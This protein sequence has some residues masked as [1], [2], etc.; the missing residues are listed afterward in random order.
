VIT[1]QGFETTARGDVS[2]AAAGETSVDTPLAIAP[3]QEKV[4]VTESG[5]PLGLSAEQAA[6]AI[7]I[8]GTQLDALPD[9]PD[10]LSDALQALAGSAAGP[11]GGEIFVDG[12]SNGRIPPKSA[13]LQIRLN[14]TP[15]SAEYDHPGFGRIEII[16][17]PGSDTYHGQASVR[18]NSSALNTRDPFSSNE[19]DYH[20]LTA[21]ADTSGPLVKG[22]ASY[23][24]DFERR[25]IDNAQLVNATVMDPQFTLQ[26]FNRSLVVPQWRTSVSP[27]LDLQ[28]GS[29]NALTLR[30]AYTQTEQDNAGIGGFVLPS[31]AYDITSRQH[32]VQVGDTGVYGKIVNEL[33]MQWTR[34]ESGQTPLAFD[35]TVE[36]QDAFTSG[37]ATVGLSNH[38]EDHLE[39]Q[40]VLSVSKG[41]HSIRTGFRLRDALVTDVSR[42]GFNG[43]VTF[44]GTFGPEL[45]AAG[46]PVLGPDG[47]PVLVPVTSIERYRR[48]M[49]LT[50]LGYSA[51]QI[52]SLGG[53][54]SQ[55]QL[56]G[57]DPYASVRQWD[58]GAFLQD[59]WKVRP[60]LTLGLGMRLESQSNLS[61]DVDIAPRLY[62][63]WSPGFTGRGTPKTVLRAGAGV[64]YD[65]VD[66]SLVL[67]ARRFDGGA[68]KRFLVTDP[69]ILDQIAYDPTTGDVTSLPAF[70]ALAGAA[71]PQVIRLLASNLAAPETLQA[72][73]GV[74]RQLPG[75]FTANVTYIHSNTWRALRS[76]VVSAPL[77]LA[78]DGSAVAYQ[79]ESTGHVRQDQFVVGLNRRF[80]QRLSL[81]A[82]Y[83]LNW[84]RSDTDG[85]GSFP[86]NSAD[87][88]AD[89]GRASND[90]RHRFIL[91]GSVT[92][93]GD[94]RVSPFLIASSGAPYNITI[95]RDVNG[96]TVF[97]D[98]PA[99]AS[100]PTRPGVVDTPWGPLDPNPVAGEVIIPRNLGQAPGFFTLNLRISRTIR[101]GRSRQAQAGPTD[102]PGGGPGGP[103]GG[104][105]AGGGPPGG[106]PMGP[107]PGGWGGG[108][109]RGGWGGGDR[110]RGDQ[111]S[112][113]GLTVMLYAQNALNHVNPAAPVGNLSSPSF[114]ESLASAGGFGRGPAGFA[115]SGN[116]AIELQLRAS[117]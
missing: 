89:W 24:V 115:M 64:F 111:G 56:S 38:L 35:P 97:T 52:R 67:D 25:A 42:Q 112:G 34:Q 76:R 99:Y 9:D 63:S 109:G 20:R 59:D 53:G 14:S 19:P 116:R 92:L 29:A 54:A 50:S 87:P 79:Y 75:N 48:T 106:G 90:I 68:P 18:F 6:G 113:P 117:F 12:F 78:A 47:Q 11:N 27:R 16:T 37:G 73:L 40:D 80:D 95:G 60:D 70:E 82:R 1:R 44:A 94:V 23:F 46:H 32:L 83:F 81:S 30:Y 62:A 33:R 61:S 88:S 31:L 107:P 2:V 57:G 22:K 41:A 69:A 36:V 49:L 101:F 7:V 71:Q 51:S 66:D 103:P 4:T 84:A 45:D 58:L 26:Q 110:G 98:R 28:L 93:P 39:L 5:A 114:G 13:I 77:T 72:S 55:L 65:R 43:D 100:D 74:D 104:A 86:A 15:F 10:E 108:G 105:P 21:S 8:E 91:M 102:G 85:A 96:D 17:K 3:V